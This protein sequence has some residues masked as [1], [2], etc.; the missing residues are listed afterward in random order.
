MSSA[1]GAS[2]W[3]TILQ[4][5]VFHSAWYVLW[6]CIFFY[7]RKINFLNVLMVLQCGM[8]WG[9]DSKKQ[10]EITLNP[11]QILPLLFPV[12]LVYLRNLQYISD[13]NVNVNNAFFSAQISFIR[14]WFLA[15]VFPSSLQAHQFY[16]SW[17]W[18][19]SCQDMSRFLPA[20]DNVICCTECMGSDNL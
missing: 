15:T 17:S 5:I 12:S 13:N 20:S 4:E 11:S 2:R 9:T 14:R 3:G 8:S 10:F 7:L 18:S 19:S 1:A 16:F 6:Y